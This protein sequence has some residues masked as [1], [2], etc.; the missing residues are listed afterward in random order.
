MIE[1]LR[2]SR[3]PRV[4]ADMALHIN[5]VTLAIQGAVGGRVAEIQ[6]TC[7]SIEPMPWAVSQ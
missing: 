3:A 1:A 5:E 6:T 7:P 2:E 4:S